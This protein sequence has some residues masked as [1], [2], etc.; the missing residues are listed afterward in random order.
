VNGASESDWQRLQRVVAGRVL[1]PGQPGFRSASVPFNKRFATTIPGGVVSVANVA[2]VPRVIEW[3]QEVGVDV[4]ARSGGH[5]YGGYSVGTGLVIDLSALNTVSAD[6][7]TGLVTAAGGA[8]TDD[9]YAA[10]QPHEMA[11][12]LGNGASVGVGGLTLGGGS[13]AVSR[14]FGLTA[15]T[16]VRTEIVTADGRLRRCDAQENTALYWACCGGG[17]GNFGINVSFTFQA[18]PVADVSTCL[19][20]WDRADAPKVLSVLQ[21]IA[22][23]APDEFSVRLGVSTTGGSDTVVSAVGH[24]LGPASELREL[25][26]P[27]LA[28]ARPVREDIAD[29]TFWQAKDYLLHETSAGAFA[30]RTNFATEPLPDEAIAT[31]LS[32]IERWP[33]SDNPDGGGF[34]MFAWG[35]AIN[36]VAPTDTAFVHRDAQYLVAV[37]TSWAEY[38]VPAVADANLRWLAGLREALAPYVSGAAYQNFIDP[39]LPDWRTAYYGVN[40]PRLVEIKR[41]VDP[42]G[43]FTFGQG[44]G[45]SSRPT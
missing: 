43:F 16:L 9:V 29:R 7:S 14:K 22:R 33:G 38:D 26:E 12:P 13:A 11:F 1:R 6:G 28:V 8:R 24:H 3:A 39:D 4:V 32:W 27:V 40:Y 17:G 31:M 35:G 5:S 10:I 21:E 18:H 30:V 23:Q 36:R 42:N 2:D 45:P 20:L 41:Q 34:A 15:D 25:L 44:I 19:L 37:D